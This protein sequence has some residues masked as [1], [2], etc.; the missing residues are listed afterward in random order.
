MNIVEMNGVIMIKS[1]FQSSFLKLMLVGLAGALSVFPANA[2]EKKISDVF[3][4]MPDS[5]VPYLTEN[6]RLDMIDF[7]TMNMKAEVENMFGE[8]SEMLSLSDNY[9]KLQLNDFTVVEMKLMKTDSLMC[10][11]SMHVVY[12][13]KTIGRE[14]K[15]STVRKYTSEWTFLEEVCLTNHARRLVS[16]DSANSD[17]L[18]YLGRLLNNNISIEATLSSDENFLLLVPHYFSLTNDDINNIRDKI[19]LRTFKINL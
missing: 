6:N 2:Q 17:D 15:F 19:T 8:K 16:F 5:L 13:V 12:L 1:F 10:D 7:S 9:L 18:S 4:A 3:A 11:S 14:T